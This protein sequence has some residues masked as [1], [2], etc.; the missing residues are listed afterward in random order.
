M[1][2]AQNRFVSRLSLFLLG[3]FCVGPTADLAADRDQGK[4]AAGQEGLRTLLDAP[5][6]FVKR[7]PYMAAHIYDDYLTY[8]PGGGIYV[9]ENPADP[10]EKHV[11]RPVI[12]PTTPETLGEGVYRDPELSWDAK[13]IV[14]SFKGSAD[15]N[16][17]IYEI[18]LEG[19]GLRRLTNPDCDCAKPPQEN[20]IGRGHHDVT[21]CYLPDGRIVFTSTRPRALV[22]CFNSGVDTLHIMEADGTNIRPISSNLTTEFDPSVLDDGRILYGRWEYVDKTALYMQSLWTVSPDGRMEEALFAN[23]LAK[24]TALLD[25]RPVPGTNLV[26]ASLT[27]HNGQ[28]VG[29]IAAIDMHRGKNELAAITNFTPEYPTE[30]DQG[31]T[32][33]PCD[34]WPLSADV[35]L[36][37]NNADGDGV[38][39]IIH[40]D[41]RRE[42]V[43][44]ER[45]ISCY[46]P[47]LIKPRRLPEKI[48]PH[49]DRAQPAG[50]FLVVDIYQGLGGIPRGTIKRLRVVEE[51]ARVSGLPPGGRWWNQAFLVSWQGAYIV[52][53]I[54][55]VVPVHED[56]SAYFEA[57]PGRAIYFEA[58]DADGREIQ[59]MRTFVQAVP[60]V[61]RSCIGCHENKKTAAVRQN[62]L[63][64]AM[65]REPA[66]PEPESWGTGYIDYPT[67]IQPILD[68]RCVRC[69]GGEEDIAG[70]VDLSGGW[71]WA[72]NISYE[73]LIKN[74]LTAFLNCNN[75]SV[76]TSEILPPRTIGSG[77]AGLGELLAGG[78]DGQIKDL[79]P[80]ERDLI[81][82]WMDTNSNYFGTWDYTQNAT[83]GA[84]LETK[85]PLADVMRQAGCTE[86]HAAGH[87]G[88]DWVNLQRPEWSRILRAPTAKGQ[89]GLGLATC[90]NRKAKAG[91]PLVTQQV[92]PPDIIKPS[93]E[94][95]YDPSGDEHVSFASTEN[96]H[97]RA[98]L[99]IIRQARSE[100]LASPRVDMPGAEIT[101]GECRLLYPMPVPETAQPIAA[102]LRPDYAVEL[103]WQRTAATIGLQYELHR[104]KTPDFTAT[105][106]TLI[107]R[108]TAGRYA[109][110]LVPAGTWHYAMVVAPCECAAGASP[111][112]SRPSYASIDVHEPPMPTIPTGLAA[113]ALSGEIVLNWEGSDEIQLRYDVYRAKAGTTEFQKLTPEPLRT[114][115]FSDVSA[116]PGTKYAY[117]VRAT[118][119]RG[120]QTGMSPAVEATPLPEIKEPVFAVALAE[121]P[122]AR[123]VDGQQ[124]EGKL[125]AGATIADGALQLGSTGFATFKSL[126]EFNIGPAITVECWLR[127]EKESQMPV[128]ACCGEWGGCGWFLQRIGGGWRWY[129]GGAVCDGGRGVVGGWCHLVGA[130]TGK[131]AILYQDGKQVAQVPCAPDRT[132]YTGPLVLGQ[133]AHQSPQYQVQGRIAGVKI[134]RRALKPDE[135]AAEFNEGP[136]WQSVRS[137][138]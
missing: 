108:T 58:L 90:R 26:A 110:P 70:G 45:G 94:P 137:R 101:P 103:S 21:P 51:T 68:R 88:N 39:Q 136:K 121:K 124:V 80:A 122:T 96:E 76:H 60:G 83:C 48:S 46:A 115:S 71:T 82:A 11:V 4:P 117:A 18:G 112:R 102:R 97:Y 43:H 86:C 74:R 62:A 57:P 63:P 53:N 81:M 61:T 50:R 66:R 9:V 32:R 125:N 129:V 12:D 75:G 15:G 49:A 8:H 85:G 131:T 41:G 95:P 133:Y 87:V 104:G 7:H 14:F 35:M 10:P 37:A 106:E 38:I 40:R 20:R 31:L 5:M 73:T 59:R 93:I 89:G 135:V 27:P 3:L 119:L 23:N 29:A 128:V 28:S 34:P 109:D 130:F 54:L 132:P 44:A 36:I 2:R 98:M 114:P 123:L 72:F 33:G 67:M 126:P 134:Y 127:I 77:A 64:V 92:Q 25:A 13:K 120:R 84:I 17:C 65:L 1:P 55:G 52:K 100:A 111:Q 78:H 116:E 56:G 99:A 91:Y 105:D 107:A 69:H 138:P 42:L 118:D 47:M 30:M 79:T 16:T 113:R 24:P 6:L 22:P 19:K